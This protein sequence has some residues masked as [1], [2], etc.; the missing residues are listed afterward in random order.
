MYAPVAGRFVGRDPIGYQDSLSLFSYVGESPTNY[1]D[2]SGKTKIKLCFFWHFND[3]VGPKAFGS[4][5]NGKDAYNTFYSSHYKISR[6][7][8]IKTYRDSFNFFVEKLDECCKKFGQ[9]C[10]GKRKIEWDFQLHPAYSTQVPGGPWPA[11]RMEN[12]LKS[13]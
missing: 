4:V 10:P 13:L 11:E 6:D 2:P 12:L 7:A 9:H 8:A 1:L 5:P 3:P